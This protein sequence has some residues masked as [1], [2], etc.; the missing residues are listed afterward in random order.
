MT[1]L[2][3]DTETTGTR[4]AQVIEA[5]WLRLDS[6]SSLQVL[7]QFEERYCPSE[8][9]SLGALATHHIYDEELQG[10]RPH[11]DFA[12]PADTQYIIGHNIDYDWQVAGSPNVK[13]ICTLALSRRYFPKLDSHSQSALI[14]H[15][16]RAGARARL[17]QAHSALADVQNCLDLLRTLVQAIGTPVNTWEELWLHSEQAR[18]P[19]TMPFGKHRGMPIADLPADYKAWLL[20]QDTLD[21]HVKLA[22]Q[23]TL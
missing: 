22:V 19:A 13:R 6:P 23:A 12:L 3:F 17:K 9:I 16:D 14:Y 18:I 7:E 2:L 20:R 1:A 5:A 8:K 15:I 4:N 11:T 10:C 21:P